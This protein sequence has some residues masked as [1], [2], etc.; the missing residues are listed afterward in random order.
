MSLDIRLPIGMMFALL[1]AMLGIY[2]LAT[3]SDAEMYQ[4]SLT[5]NIN[6]IWGAVLFLFGGSM[7]AFALRDRYK[8]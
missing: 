7:L 8:K 1:G 4:A 5:I 2:G 3:S 6:L